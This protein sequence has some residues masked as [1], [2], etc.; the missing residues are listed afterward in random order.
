MLVKVDRSS[1]ANSLEVRIPF[2]DH[3]I[4]EFMAKVPS[5]FKYNFLTS[6]YLL[7]KLGEKYLPRDIVYRPKKGFGIPVADWLLTTLKKP[8]ENIV[9]N[10]NSFIN[11][12]FNKKYTQNLF[13]NHINKKQNN[14]KL[15]YTLFTLENWYNSQV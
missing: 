10:P 13:A 4:V 9:N 8:M 14:R 2:L 3:N 11:S 5:S 1:M 7:K 12:I 6:K 15:L